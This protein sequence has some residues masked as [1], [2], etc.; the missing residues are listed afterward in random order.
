MK[1]A[2]TIWVWTPLFAQGGLAAGSR[3]PSGL[4]ILKPDV[5]VPREVLLAFRHGVK[6]DGVES[7]VIFDVARFPAKTRWAYVADGINKSGFNPL[8]GLGP[9]LSHPFIDTS[10]L[11]QVPRGETGV[12][13][14][15]FGDRYP[16][17]SDSP[18]IICSHL[19]TLAL[20]AHAAGATVIGV[21][22]A[23]SHLDQISPE[24]FFGD[25]R[26]VMAR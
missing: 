1:A 21:L 6:A 9:L 7:L 15:S 24:S 25:F 19:Q 14:T 3:R 12:V 2:N 18:G 26:Q 16:V 11:Y 23:E 22:L 8:R 4:Q 17:S 10:R 20:L 13:A 5:R